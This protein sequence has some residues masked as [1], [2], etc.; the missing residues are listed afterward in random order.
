VR[1]L[2]RTPAGTTCITR[3]GALAAALP[4]VA[5][6]SCAPGGARGDAPG[7]SKIGAREVTLRWSTWGDQSS[8]MVE[9]S[10]KGAA[11]FT[12]RFPQI[13]VV[14]EP[15]LSGVADKLFA[16]MVAG[17]APDVMGQC[18]NVLPTWARKGVLVDLEPLIKRDLKAVQVRDF[19]ELQYD[20]FW[21]EEAGRF[22]VPMYMG[23]SGLYYNT[24]RFRRAAV[25]APDE[26][27]DWAK[28]H[29]AMRRLTSLPN[30]QWGA[31]IPT[32]RGTRQIFVNANGG[33]TVDPKNDTKAAFDQK[34]ALD[35]YQWLRDRMWQ[36]N[37]AIQRGQQQG[38]QFAQ[39]VRGRVATIV[40]GSFDLATMVRE[41]SSAGT[42]AWDVA[43][44]PRGPVAR[45]NR[46]T[47]DGWSLWREG[48]SQPEAWELL[49]FLQTDEWWDINMPLTFQQPTRISLQARYADVLKRANPALADKRVEI[50]GDPVTKGYARPQ[51]NWRLDDEA[52]KSYQKAWD[53]SV[54]DNKAPVLDAFRQAAVEI[55]N[56]HK[57]QL[58]K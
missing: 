7:A 29:D 44:L 3:R 10:A 17:A 15:Q 19:H 14:P 16:E 30:E 25:A 48:K 20:Y 33:E 4:L 53:D 50:F 23:T 35:A 36:D 39:L 1:R 31:L 18:C 34:P 9:A 54:M 22:A 52:L 6:A 37:V 56:L 26:T 57:Q 5:L 13:R 42:A 12:Q 24:D 55:D 8:P 41:A 46:A 43:L 51:T 38:N 45:R 32:S 11:V 40:A 28:W 47:V 2:S 21:L 58:G 49:K 27:W